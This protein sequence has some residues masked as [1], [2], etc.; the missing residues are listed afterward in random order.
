[1]PGDGGYGMPMGFSFDPADRRYVDFDYQAIPADKLRAAIESDAQNAEEAYLLVAKRI[2]IRLGVTID[3]RKLNRLI[4]ACG[5]APLMVEIRQV[6]FNRQAGRN[7]GG[8]G[9]GYGMMSAMGGSYGMPGDDGGG[10]PGGM[11]GDSSSYGS[12]GASMPGMGMPGGMPGDD[13]SGGYGGYGGGYG[14][15]AMPDMTAHDKPVELFGVVYIYNPVD[16]R[17]LRLQDDTATPAAPTTPTEAPA[18]E[19]GG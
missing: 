14:Q 7:A 19:T 10:M 11:P 9:G 8:M 5:N 17:K 16:V 18:T 3:Q 12:Y 15:N 4:T 1:M 6:R 2:P 13:G